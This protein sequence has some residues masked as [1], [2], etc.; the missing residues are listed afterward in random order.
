MSRAK[1]NQDRDG[2]IALAWIIWKYSTRGVNCDSKK[3]PKWLKQRSNQTGESEDQLY[4]FIQR[5]ILPAIFRRNLE[6]GVIARAQDKKL[7][8]VA[9]KLAP[10]E[11]YR[12]ENELMA[13]ALSFQ[14]HGLSPFSIPE[15]TSVMIRYVVDPI[16]ARKEAIEIAH[17][18]P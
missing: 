11:L 15:V 4:E 16:K 8:R 5:V 2:E 17:E 3:I 1:I 13:Q 6:L 7:T 12:D 10:F 18:S 14:R 9:L